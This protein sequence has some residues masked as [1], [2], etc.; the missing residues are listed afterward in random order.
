MKKVFTNIALALR[1]ILQRPHYFK[2]LMLRKL[3]F[4]QRYKWIE[5]NS[6]TDTPIPKP[7]VYK[8]HLT[9][10]CNLSC[11]MCMLW[12]ES[13][14]SHEEA[15]RY[16][17]EELAW[18][19]LESFIEET[20]ASNISYIFSGGE[21]FVYSH[22]KELLQLLRKKKC[23][24]T[25]CTN[26]VLLNRYEEYLLD[27]PLLSILIS[28]DGCEKQNDAIRGK[29]MYKKVISNIRSLVQ[30]QRVHPHVGTQF[31]IQEENYHSMLA[32]S[33][34]MSLLGI[35]W[36]LFNLCWSITA[37]QASAYETVL[38]EK[39]GVKAETHKGYLYPCSMD[40]ELLE[41]NFTEIK[42]R[43]WPMQIGCYFKESEDIKRFFDAPMTPFRNSLCYKQWIRMEVMP[44]GDI[45]PCIQFPDISFGNIYT[46]NHAEIWN[47][48]QFQEFRN[49]IKREL[50]PVCSRCDAIY[51]YDPQRKHL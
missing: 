11:K 41:K 28:L 46:D 50:L 21:P 16:Q 13:G 40:Q 6:A 23:A 44:S 34:E 30:P 15:Q 37:E 45:T 42:S 17:K 12:G 7:L 14:W 10:G 2:S 38:K 19:R 22:I 4:A 51:L 47:S 1:M 25:F 39:F 24:A 32:F 48:Q 33:H 3:S 29:G 26:G 9:H 31:T 18:E 43:Q 36:V 5:K 8:I 27:N 49:H 35:D 20:A